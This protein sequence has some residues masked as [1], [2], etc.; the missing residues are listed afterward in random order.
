MIREDMK[1][2]LVHIPVVLT[3]AVVLG[4]VSGCNFVV[5]ESA[6]TTATPEPTATFTPTPK[7][8]AFPTPS[9]TRLGG[10]IQRRPTATPRPLRVP[11]SESFQRFLTPTPT[12]TPRPSC[13]KSDPLLRVLPSLVEVTGYQSNGSRSFGS[14]F[15]VDSQDGYVLTANHV[16]SNA[17]RIE[18]TLRNGAIRTVVDIFYVVGGDVALLEADTMGFPA[19]V[20]PEEGGEPVAGDCVY[21][22]G[23]VDGAYV[24]RSGVFEGY[25]VDNAGNILAHLGFS[26]EPGM[27]GGPLVNR[28]GEVAAVG[29]LT[30]VAIAFDSDDLNQI[31]TFAKEAPPQVTPRPTVSAPLGGI[32]GTQ[33]MASVNAIIR[34]AGAQRDC[35]FAQTWHRE[36]GFIS[37]T[38]EMGCRFA[39][40]HF[41]GAA[42]LL[43]APD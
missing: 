39:V 9:G 41:T 15:I 6:A 24:T 5:G 38:T 12:F 8:T 10:P 29:S 31:L 27:S 25:S 2:A 21:A 36:R 26:A 32:T 33:A 1:V 7:P 22:L 18:I 37:V 30:N 34:A 28:K 3:L 19:L 11:L 14:G 35:G 23:V 17:N 43:E 13:Y 20:F 16:I 42:G 4:L 40:D